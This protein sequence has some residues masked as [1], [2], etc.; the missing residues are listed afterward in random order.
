MAGGTLVGNADGTETGPGEQPLHEAVALGQL[1]ESLDHLAIDESEVTGVLRQL[2]AGGKGVEEAVEAACGEPFH[3][4]VG[5]A[6]DPDAV[7]GVVVTG[8]PQ[9]DELQDE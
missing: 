3:R 7:D 2:G 6:I 4:G 9:L 5:A 1:L 8:L